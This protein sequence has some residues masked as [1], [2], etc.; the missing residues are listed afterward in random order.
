M[1][2]SVG[3]GLNPDEPLAIQLSGQPPKGAHPFPRPLEASKLTYAFTKE[4]R[5]VPEEAVAN[6]S[7]ESVCTD[8]MITA[9][10]NSREGWGIPELK[11]YGPLSLL[12]TASC[13]HYATECFEGMKVYRGIDGKLRLF[14]P[15]RNASRLRS[16]ASRIA[17]PDFDPEE[18]YKLIIALVSVDC[19]K[20]L[21]KPKSFLYLRPTMI[22]T[23]PQLHVRAPKQALL[24]I[25]MSF[26]PR[27]DEELG[28]LRLMTSPENMVRAWAGG[29]GHAKV[30][31][32]YGPSVLAFQDAFQKGLNQVLWLYGP[33]GQC[34]EAGGSNF[35]VVWRRK[36]GVKELITAPLEDQLILDGVTRRSC[37]DLARERLS[38][39]LTVTEHKFTI[40]ELLEAAA[41]GRL[42]ESFSVGT[43]YA[44][45]PVSK[46]F[47]RGHDVEIPMGREGKGGPITLQMKEWLNDIVYGRE[48]HQWGVVVPDSG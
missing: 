43:M 24:Y 23:Q 12:P 5:N 14:R 32:N 48:E 45:C 11:P 20:W 26:V 42:M 46:I 44:V 18:L 19:P 4:P 41:E 22:G 27:V 47:H 1:D 2:I 35:L 29:F 28:S 21:P 25:I 36:D 9:Q 16:S 38:S 31:A 3:S 8:H 34:T 6:A 13:L 30:G 10:W 17:L 33:D 40:S 39:E 37:I 15:E 7:D